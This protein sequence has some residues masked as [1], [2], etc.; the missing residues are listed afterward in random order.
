[1]A[2]NLNHLALFKELENRANDGDPI[3]SNLRSRIILSIDQI[4]AILGDIR[5]FFRHFTDHSINH[6]LRIA[7]NIGSILTPDQVRKNNNGNAITSMDIFLMI[8]SAL[9]HDIGMVIDEK[10]LKSLLKEEQ[11]KLFMNSWDKG[12]D[13]VDNCEWLCN[14]ISRLAIAEYVRRYHAKRSM[15]IVLDKTRIPTS[16]VDGANRISYWLG[17]IAAAHG[18]NFDEV[19]NLNEFPQ[20]TDIHL[21]GGMVESC[22]PRFIALCLRIGDLLDIN[23]ARACPIIQRFSEPL[24]LLSIDHW[25]QYQDIEIQ[26]LAPNSELVIAGTSPSQNS[27]RLLREWFSWLKDEL[28]SA[29]A[30]QN[31]DEK[32]YDLKLGRV[33]YSVT[34]KTINGKPVYE[35]LNFRFNLDEEMVFNRLF[36]KVLYGRTELAIRELIQNAIDAQRAQIAKKSIQIWR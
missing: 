27:E 32:R 6:S 34:P 23:T 9:V 8:S 3:A 29:V 17:K 24:S 13:E 10:F 22:N 1:M 31:Q 11:F 14:G 20:R 18:M 7:H 28:A 33:R 36:G 26:G 35:F 2:F 19:C 4:S 5:I 16:L 21:T 12:P 30:I 15:E 25:S